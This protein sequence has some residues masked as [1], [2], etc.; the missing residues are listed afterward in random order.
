[1][2]SMYQQYYEEPKYRPSFLSEPRV[3]AGLLGRKTKRG[4]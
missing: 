2:K 3:A 1:M 4:W